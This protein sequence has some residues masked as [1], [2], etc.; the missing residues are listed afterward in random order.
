MPDRLGLRR[1]VV[2]LR[3]SGGER[4][5]RRDGLVPGRAQRRACP[6]ARAREGDTSPCRRTLS[7]AAQRA[8]RSAE[9]TGSPPPGTRT[10]YVASP[11]LAPRRASARARRRTVAPVPNPSPARPVREGSTRTTA[12][13][14]SGP[15]PV[16]RPRRGPSSGVVRCAME[17]P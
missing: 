12:F 11:A 7:S 8:A 4:E 9:S 13:T 17:E 16:I 3:E 6:A 5:H 1:R 14:A 2:V 15:A 10:A